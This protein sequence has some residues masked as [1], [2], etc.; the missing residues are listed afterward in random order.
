LFDAIDCLNLFRHC[1]ASAARP[2]L[3]AHTA[4]HLSGV[5]VMIT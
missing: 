4:A 3:P 5:Q 2:S 1:G